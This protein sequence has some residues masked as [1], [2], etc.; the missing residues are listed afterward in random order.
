[1]YSP[2]SSIS[3]PDIDVV[4]QDH[5]LRGELLQ[6]EAERAD[7]RRQLRRVLLEHHENP[8]LAELRRPAHEAL[9]EEHLIG[10]GRRALIPKRFMSGSLKRERTY[11]W[12]ST[13]TIS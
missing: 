9:T 1:M 4:E 5:F 13:Y 2:V 7:V 11:G 10:G 12:T 3:A 8:R 6:I